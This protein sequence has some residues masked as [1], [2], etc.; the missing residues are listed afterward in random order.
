MRLK[1]SIFLW[2]S[3]ATVIPLSALVLGITAYS[4]R[5]YR[6]NVNDTIQ[7]GMKN[8]V[9]E[10]EFRFN[11]EREVMLS[12]ASSPVMKQFTDTLSK[13]ASGDLPSNYFDELDSL[14]N[15]LTGFQH[16]VPGVDAVR[17]MDQAGNSLVKVTFGKQQSLSVAEDAIDTVDASIL[18]RIRSFK[19]HALLYGELYTSR[20]DEN[21]NPLLNPIVPLDNANGEAVG[22]LAAESLGEQLDHLLQL[23]PR[24]HKFKIEI[25]ELNASN[26]ERHGLIL[27]S[28][29]QNILFNQPHINTP[30]LW[31]QL[32][33]DIWQKVEEDKKGVFFLDD[34][35]QL[36]FYQEF[37]PYNNL[38]VSWVV[39]LQID[40]RELTAPFNRIRIGLLIF[41]VLALLI[42]LVLADL[43]ARYI[44]NPIAKFSAALK[45]V[46]DGEKDMDFR[47]KKPAWVAEE[48]QELE[49]SFKYL[50]NTLKASE[51]ER[52]QA[53]SMLLQQAK[54]ASIGE[55]AAGIG[56][57]INNPLN[58][59][60]SYIKLIERDLPINSEQ[61]Q[62]DINGL[63]EET[64]RAGRIVKGVLN[65]A[66]Q[67]PPEY[68][69]FDMQKWLQDTVSLVAPEARKRQ[70]SLVLQD[71]PSLELYGD[72]S[73]LQ[74]VLVNLLMNAIQVS[75]TQ[76]QVE[77]A[78]QRMGAHLVRII[79]SDRGTGIDE[80]NLSKV[81]DPFFTTKV[82][83]EGSGLG[84]SI[85]LGIVQFHRGS[86]ALV[87]NLKG[88]VDAIVTLPLS[89]ST[90]ET[91]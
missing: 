84:L 81:F 47:L 53:Q 90:D 43:G 77:I 65:F 13:V 41:A 54:L 37:Y 27:Y 63:R 89:T 22:F 14:N 87:N 44:A 19:P 76:Q 18:A 73:Q 40:E 71:M 1:S 42:S 86:L 31:Q 11:Y 45:N 67:V 15:F 21:Q 39:M 91:K 38:E 74:Q 28:E 55:M 56:H 58:N 23:L 17:V 34:S 35:S 49:R 79:V 12:L 9:S 51:D 70:V 32:D 10:L 6:H 80:T 3:L 2:V 62:Q 52:D 36:Y 48:L 4:E 7:G 88:G 60:L 46:A 64:L 61:L 75:D 8:I 78:V 5:L 16:S 33:K 69:Y 57:E 82:V 29:I 83:G 68:S 26:S 66:R 24:G 59:I 25:V 30:K 72:R 50:V 85:S 20:D